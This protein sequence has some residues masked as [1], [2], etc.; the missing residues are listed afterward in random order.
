MIRIVAFVP[1]PDYQAVAAELGMPI[2]SIGPTRGRCLAKLRA[3]LAKLTLTGE[4]AMKSPDAA[5]DEPMDDLDFAILDGIRELFERADP[6]PADLPERIRF[7]L[8]MRDLE[9]EVARLAAAEQPHLA[10]ARRGAQPDDH[11]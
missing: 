10:G 9:A 6:M 3:L 11:L 4:S 1:R 7:S 5:P 2:G 8:A